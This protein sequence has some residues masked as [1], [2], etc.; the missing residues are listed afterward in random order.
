MPSSSGPRCCI[1]AHMRVTTPTRFSR[2]T[3]ESTSPAIP[4]I[5]GRRVQNVCFSLN[6]AGEPQRPEEHRAE[7]PQI[8][9]PRRSCSPAR[10]GRDCCVPYAF[11]SRAC[12]GA[13][14]NGGFAALDSLNSETHCEQVKFS[15]GLLVSWSLV[16]WFEA[17]PRQASVAKTNLGIGFGRELRLV[18]S[19]KSDRVSVENSEH[20]QLQ[21]QG[22]TP[23]S[24]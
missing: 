17:S 7:M 8:G 19:G 21:Q 20:H 14:R 24:G 1:A 2:E 15:E 18:T 10:E 3:L 5:I 13:C 4:H 9:R 6:S 16:F 11:G 23:I 12:R 22:I